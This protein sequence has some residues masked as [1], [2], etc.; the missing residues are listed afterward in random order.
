M[1]MADLSFICAIDQ[2]VDVTPW[3]EKLFADCIQVG[4]ECWVITLE[5]QIVGFGISNYSVTEAHL[6]KLAIAPDHQ[7]QGLGQKMLLHL[8]SMARIHGAVEMFLEVR[9][10]NST[11]IKLYEKNHFAEVGMRKGYYPA[12]ET[13]GY[14]KEDAITMA[15]PLL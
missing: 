4:Y 10:S 5:T 7:Q 15:M 8:V 3:S 13:L 6:L 11:A 1:T 2:Q 12:N 9:V 14:P